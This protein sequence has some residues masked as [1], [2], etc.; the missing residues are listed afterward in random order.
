MRY[1]ITLNGKDYEVEVEAGKAIIVD[2]TDAEEPV[3]DVVSV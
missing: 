3:P 1:I 2:V